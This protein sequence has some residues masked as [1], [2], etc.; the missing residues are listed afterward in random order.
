MHRQTW[1]ALARSLPPET[2]EDWRQGTLRVDEATGSI[3]PHRLRVRQ[4]AAADTETNPEAGVKMLHEN[5]REWWEECARLEKEKR[6]PG[7]D[8]MPNA[9]GGYPFSP[10][11]EGR[12]EVEPAEMETDEP[13]EGSEGAVV[14]EGDGS[15]KE[16]KRIKA[17]D[18]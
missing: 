9:S 8:W 5:A 18:E 7:V 2:V 14:G 11:Q 16:E 15:E 4:S 12:G 13:A 10:A 17:Q 1:L 6:E 3:A